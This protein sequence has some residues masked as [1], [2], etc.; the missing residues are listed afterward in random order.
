MDEKGLDF[1][2]V[3][4]LAAIEIFK[5]LETLE[6]P[7]CGKPTVCVDG[8]TECAEYRKLKKKFGVE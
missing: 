7:Y 2:A 6:C 8:E 4:R 1:E 5:A 3:R